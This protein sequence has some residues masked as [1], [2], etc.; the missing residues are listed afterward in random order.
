MIKVGITGNIASGKTEVEKIVKE[1]GYEVICAD[2]VSHNLL[3]SD[4]QVRQKVYNLFK[5]LDRKEIG[6]IV[7]ANLE[8]KAKLEEILHPRIRQEIESFFANNSDKKLVFASIPLLY[9]ASFEDMFDKVILVCANEELRLE[10]LLRRNNHTKEHALSRINSQM[11]EF[12][13]RGLADYIVENEGSFDEL[14]VA[15]LKLT[16]ALEL[17]E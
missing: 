9:E 12:T 4:V 17:L 5:T 6:E 11:C 3:D 13:K 1:L 16:E 8:L 2:C 7:F 10:R 15:V 14:R